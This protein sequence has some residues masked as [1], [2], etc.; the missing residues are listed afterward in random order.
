VVWEPKNFENAWHR[1]L[2]IHK[3]THEVWVLRLWNNPQWIQ[4]FVSVSI[5]VLKKFFNSRNVAHSS[6]WYTLHWCLH[7]FI[8]SLLS[9]YMYHWRAFDD[10]CPQAFFLR[11]G[12][13]QH[14]SEGPLGFLKLCSA[15]KDD[16][17][18]KLN[19]DFYTRPTVLGKLGR[20][21]IPM[22]LY[23][24][25]NNKVA[26]PLFSSSLGKNLLILKVSKFTGNWF[27]QMF[28]KN[29]HLKSV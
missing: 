29:K 5:L 1:R 12:S 20:W 18:F 2:F 19:L 10:W 26:I 15:K 11:D 27:P 25:I 23:A 13:H 24:P 28:K 9:F 6:S 14:T 17:V 4:V 22:E 16:K 21:K 3:E 7:M 8:H